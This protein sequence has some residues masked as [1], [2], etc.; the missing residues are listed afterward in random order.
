MTHRNRGVTLIELLV[1]I[2][3]LA[4]LIGLILAAIQNARAASQRASCTNNLRQLGLALHQ[5]HNIA[6]SFPPGLR[7]WNDPYPFASWITRI[8]PLLENEPAWMEAVADYSQQP[9]FV[10]PPPHRN[11][12][13]LMPIVLCPAGQKQI[14]TT[15]E[16]I[17]AAFTY[18]LGVS[19]GVGGATNGV[20]FLN[21]A[22]R[23][24]DITDGTSQTLLIGER[25]PSP[26]N[27]FGWW[28]AGVGQYLDGSADYVL[29]ADE[30]NRTYRAPTCPKGPYAYQPG[31]PNDMCD[32]FHFWS[33]HSG[34][35]NF[36]FADGST[37]F[38]SYPANPILPALAT[39]AGGEIVN[40]DD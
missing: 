36:V 7:V 14:G 21:S 34:G 19:G 10:G 1:V 23:F 37:R 15:D 26:D 12:A 40:F 25:P 22:I 11:L 13:R 3:I 4:I 5:S 18:Y 17:T 27:F 39:R 33:F 6:G 31:N 38:L 32:T 8:L 29:A 20:L 30:I 2:A 35:A 24:A 16:N 9:N 28:Y